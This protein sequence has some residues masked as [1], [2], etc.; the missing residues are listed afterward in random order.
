MFDADPI[1]VDN[2]EPSQFVTAIKK[3]IPVHALQINLP[4]GFKV[5]TRQGVVEGKPGD[6]LMFGA[7]GEKYPCDREIFEKTY[8]VVRQGL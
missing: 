1:T 6:Y 8:T 7:E 3:P 4:E 2:W 5:T